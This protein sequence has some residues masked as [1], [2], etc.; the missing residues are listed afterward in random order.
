[1]TPQ[2]IS[3]SELATWDRCP[4]SWLLK[5]YMGYVPEN[6]P[7]TGNMQLGSRVAVAMEGYYGYQWD[8]LA[9]LAILYKIET[10]AHPDAAAELA[11]EQDLAEAMVSGYLEWVAAEGA[12]ADLE[13]VAAETDLQ[14]PL[15]GNNGV[16]LRARMDRVVRRISDGTL[17]FVDDKT[18]ANFE[19][20][21]VL[22]LDPQ[23]RFY[24]MMQRLAVLEKP[25][26][27]LV[28]GGIINTLRRVKRTSKSKPPYYR[29]DP[30][31]FNP[32]QIQATYLR[33]VQLCNEIL[34]AR[35]HLDA[36]YAGTQSPDG[37][38]WPATLQQ[39]NQLQRSVL[40]PT[41]IPHDC[42]W[43][44]PFSS[45]LCVAMD[46]GSDWPGML[47]D[48]GRWRQADPYEYYRRDGLATIREELAKL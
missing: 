39:I 25:G 1:M 13:V 20:H 12:D 42:A 22:D 5:Y 27:P 17:L 9:V 7:V 21:E 43:S 23:M 33:T 40:R 30:F 37:R 34:A 10:D 2:T 38:I 44:C 4:R 35:A 11:A 26:A 8:P 31:D 28:A 41:P 6:P 32:E 36:T 29:R 46:D 18:A 19:K 14:V 3:Q 47:R 24:A 45:G 48:T 16:V 15:P